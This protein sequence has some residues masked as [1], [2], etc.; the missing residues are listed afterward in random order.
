MIRSATGIQTATDIPPFRQTNADGSVSQAVTKVGGHIDGPAGI[1]VDVQNGTFPDGAVVTITPVSEAQFPFQLTDAQ[2]QFFT[3]SGGL[4]LDFGGKRAQIYLNVSIPAA[5]ADNEADRWMVVRALP[6]GAET[7]FDVAD[8][9]RIIDGRIATSSPPCPGVAAAAVY[10]FLR[11]SRQLSVL[12]GAGGIIP[13][14]E[15]RDAS[16]LVAANVALEDPAAFGGSGLAMPG[17]SVAGIDSAFGDVLLN[18]KT[19]CVPVLS[20]RVTGVPN[21]VEVSVDPSILT[22]A[23]VELVVADVNPVR[24]TV[25]QQ[26]LYRP[27]PAKVSL[28]GAAN[29]AISV[30]AFKAD[31]TFRPIDPSH[32]QQAGRAFVI[33]EIANVFG[34]YRALVVANSRTGKQ[35]VEPLLPRITPTGQLAPVHLPLVRLLLEGLATDE[36]DVTAIDRQGL[37]TP[38]PQPVVTAYNIGNGNMLFSAL[39]GTIDPTPAEIDAYNANLQPGD[40]PA[41]PGGGTTRAVLE[42]YFK[43]P[44][45]NSLIPGPSHVLLDIDAGINETIDGGFYVALDEPPNSIHYL[46]VRHVDGAEDRAKLPEFVITVIN[47]TTNAA[48]RRLTGLVPPNNDT[49]VI[50]VYGSGSAT[51]TLETSAAALTDVDPSAP[52]Q[53]SFSAPVD[54]ATVLAQ[55]T[56]F[57]SAGKKIDGEIVMS[58]GV[59]SGADSVITFIP[60]NPLVLDEVYRINLVGVLDLL[61][62]PLAVRVVPVTTYTPRVESMYSAL[63]LD[64]QVLTFADLQVMHDKT[65][66]GNPRTSLIAVSS[67]DFGF[68]LHA[69]DVSDPQNPLGL[70]EAGGGHLTRRVALRTHASFQLSGDLTFCNAHV[71]NR[72][73]TGA[74]AVGTSSDVNDTH[75]M[76]YD[77][78]DPNAPCTL[79]SKTITT[80]PEE[81]GTFVHGTFRTLSLG[82]G[83]AGILQHSTGYAAYMAIREVGTAAVDIGTNVPDVP[84]AQRDTEGLFSGDYT[85]VITVDDARILAL[86]NNFGSGATLD[87][88]DPNLSP[89]A[90]VSVDTGTPAA[91]LAGG[92]LAH[93]VA[94]ASNVGVDKNGDGAIDDSELFA[95]AYVGGKAGITIVDMTDSDNPT[96]LTTFPIKGIVRQVA[97]SPDGRR[98]YVGGDDS[99]TGQQGFFIV[100]VSNPFAQVANRIIYERHY[101]E[102]ERIQVDG[103]APLRVRGAQGRD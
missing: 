90:S 41:E 19:F 44:T 86:N 32:V 85:D 24:P 20:G 50:N 33:V 69:I 66:G 54:R 56:V 68:K 83:G 11:S 82:A 28:E 37:P 57:D 89:I 80:N 9:A 8:T 16:Y 53:L 46:S 64:G 71:T 17:F 52:L 10:G 3:Y 48:V 99:T 58:S 94:Y 100:D 70:G 76:F 30:Q 45:T 96:P 60:K 72:K 73:F 29:D 97:A 79:G 47:H 18:S 102:V 23:D 62:R 22:D 14:P 92:T 6:V 87:V 38:F 7:V 91:G 15:A 2:R 21:R 103:A 43:N 88:L 12:T 98:L 25:Q 1:G 51:P 67:N 55:L 36:F 49:V 63:N 77:V 75:I 84:L 34:D 4:K 40:V 59:F 35:I 42:T 5:A 13:N 39:R 95:F 93:Q 74:L 27:F 101:I 26:H 78:T 81:S 61:G 65:P 31:G